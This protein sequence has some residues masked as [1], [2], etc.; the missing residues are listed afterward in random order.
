VV[1]LEVT[2]LQAN[3]SYPEH[4]IKILD[5][6]DYAMQAASS[7][8]MG[9]PRQASTHRT[10]RPWATSGP[11]AQCCFSFSYGIFELFQMNLKPSK[12]HKKLNEFRKNVKSLMLGRFK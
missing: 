5:Q 3:L 12:I 8:A 10:V 6:K 1:L 2:P 11:V 4:P 9:R 7:S